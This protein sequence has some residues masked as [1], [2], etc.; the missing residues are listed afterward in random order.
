MIIFQPGLIKFLCINTLVYMYRRYLSFI[1]TN[2]D[3]G[4]P[5][6]LFFYIGVNIYIHMYRRY[7]EGDYSILPSNKLWQQSTIRDN[8]YWTKITTRNSWNGMRDFRFFVGSSAERG[9]ALCNTGATVYI[10]GWLGVAVAAN[11]WRMAA[12]E[13]LCV[14]CWHWWFNC[15]FLLARR[16]VGHEFRWYL[17]MKSLNVTLTL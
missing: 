2:D 10:D 13:L 17:R 14:P 15:G 5:I 16:L 8:P 9:K 6:I 4:T 11:A 12:G 7:S 3:R 1:Q